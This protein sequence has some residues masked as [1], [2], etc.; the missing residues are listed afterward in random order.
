MLIL[1]ISANRAFNWSIVYRVMATCKKC[2]TFSRC[3]YVW[4]IFFQASWFVYAETWNMVN[5]HTSMHRRAHAQSYTHVHIGNAPQ[6]RLQVR[7]LRWTKILQKI[8]FQFE[9]S[10]LHFEH[11][12]VSERACPSPRY[13]S[14]L[15]EVKQPTYNNSTCLHTMACDLSCKQS[16]CDPQ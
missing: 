16:Q 2:Y 5:R 14:M 3:L 9:W 12:D 10:I 1:T 15:L 7:L 6:F 8:T 11:C 13:T 4:M